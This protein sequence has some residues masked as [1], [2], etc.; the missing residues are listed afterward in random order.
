MKRS[1]SKKIHVCFAY[2]YG[3]SLGD[4]IVVQHVY[5]PITPTELNNIRDKIRRNAGLPDDT[6]IIILS[7]Q[8][9]EADE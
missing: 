8:R 3:V 9:Y 5:T 1:K 2:E 7:W 4:V 6:P